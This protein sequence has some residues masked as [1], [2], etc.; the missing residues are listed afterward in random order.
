[1]FLV[2]TSGG[3][4]GVKNVANAKPAANLVSGF[5]PYPQ[6]QKIKSATVMSRGPAGM[7]HR[8][9]RYEMQSVLQTHIE[10]KTGF[11]KSAYAMDLSEPIKR[12]ESKQFAKSATPKKSITRRVII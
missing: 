9:V 8:K 6:R 5:F 7:T 12:A 11:R 10:R 2:E 3:I 1:M 4:G